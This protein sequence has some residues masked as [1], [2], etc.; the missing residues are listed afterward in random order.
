MRDRKGQNDDDE[1]DYATSPNSRKSSRLAGHKPSDISDIPAGNLHFEIKEA[2]DLVKGD[3]VGK[4]DPY[5]V[6]TYGDKKS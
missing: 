4:S 5:A 3:I 1:D 6:L 2:K